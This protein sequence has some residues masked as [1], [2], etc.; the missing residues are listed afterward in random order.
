M[1]LTA[2]SKTLMEKQYDINGKFLGHYWET[3]RACMGKQQ[4]IIGKFQD[5]N[6]KFEDVNGTFQNINGENSKTLMGNFHDI[7]GKKLGH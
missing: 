1:T 7:N 2:K 3:S 5:I 6:G 4:G